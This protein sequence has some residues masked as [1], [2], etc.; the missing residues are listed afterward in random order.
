M[1]P[2]TIA[3][4]LASTKDIS[5]IGVLILIIWAGH[6]GIWVYGKMYDAK[7]KECERWQ[8]LALNGLNLADRATKAASDIVRSTKDRE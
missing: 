3:G 2:D 1:T 6:K 7:V 8:D 4:I 5:M